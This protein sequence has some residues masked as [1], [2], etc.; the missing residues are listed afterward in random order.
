MEKQSAQDF[1]ISPMRVLNMPEI[2]FFYVI[3]P[4]TANLDEVLDP[5]LK[6][7]YEARRLAPITESGPDIVRYYKAAGGESNLS[8]MGRA[9][10]SPAWRWF[11][12]RCRH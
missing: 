9:F 3:S 5:L 10:C 12:S 8:I 4:P 6:S 11:S 2:T 1:M 7:L